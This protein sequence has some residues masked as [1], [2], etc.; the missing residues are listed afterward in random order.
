MGGMT[1]AGDIAD[2][3]GAPP[4]AAPGARCL[5]VAPIVPVRRVARSLSFYI[6]VLGFSV[7]E[8]DDAGTF[9]YVA[10]EGV[11]VMLLDLGDADA[12][13][14]TSRYLSAYV[15]VDDPEA[16]FAELSPRLA[17]LP[18]KRYSGVLTRPDGRREFRVTDPD[19]FLMFFGEA[20][21]G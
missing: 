16:L 12:P 19:G 1:E 14:A 3:G 15:W 2:R 5:G 6:G 13:R 21:R 10:R 4:H 17:R 18:A 7:I 9:A 8:R 11:G 20:P